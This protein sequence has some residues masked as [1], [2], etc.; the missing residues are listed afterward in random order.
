MFRTSDSQ[1]VTERG[2]KRKVSS[3]RR[4]MRLAPGR[5]IEAAKLD[6]HLLVHPAGT[7]QLNES[8]AAVLALCDGTRTREEIVTQFLR[9]PVDD[10]LALDVREFLDA[11][12]R[13]GWIV[14]G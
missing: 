2:M 6:S 11:A 9:R 3:R 14:E 10:D 5:R 12:Q 1:R 8:A 7:V 4:R 13:R